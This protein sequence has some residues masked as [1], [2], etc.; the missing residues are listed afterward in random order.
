[1]AEV[2]DAHLT[3]LAASLVDGDTAVLFRQLLRDALQELIE[4]EFA[5]AIGAQPHERTDTP[6]PT[7]ATTVGR[8][9]RQLRVEICEEG[10]TYAPSSTR[11][12]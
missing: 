8:A 3:D 6:A 10:C 5:A 11:D 12:G 1:M 7:T 4:E 9:P 2:H